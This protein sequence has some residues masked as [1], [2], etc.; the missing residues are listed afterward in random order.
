MRGENSMLTRRHLLMTAVLALPTGTSTAG[1]RTLQ[2]TIDK[3]AF[4]PAEIEVRAGDAIEW[5]NNDTFAHTATVKGGFEIMLP[6]KKSGSVVLEK[7]GTVDYYCRFH[8]NM[9]GRVMVAP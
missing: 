8:P 4:S 1:A 9:K 3:M 7:A 6:P 5:V 2:I